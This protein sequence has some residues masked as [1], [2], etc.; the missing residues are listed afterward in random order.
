VANG[1]DVEDF[2]DPSFFPNFDLQYM[3][4]VQVHNTSKRAMLFIKNIKN[5]VYNEQHL[6]TNYTTFVMLIVD[7]T[8]AKRLSEVHKVRIEGN[9]FNTTFDICSWKFMYSCSF[10]F[11]AHNVCLLKQCVAM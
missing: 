2:D 10:I 6:V 5:I 8:I 3:Q 9:D 4:L 7:N 1:V 11:Y